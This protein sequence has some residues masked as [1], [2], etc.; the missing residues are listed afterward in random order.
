MQG[1]KQEATEGINERK[2][3]HIFE[4]RWG[5]RHNKGKPLDSLGLISIDL[6][7]HLISAVLKHSTCN[8]T[9]ITVVN[10]LVTT[11]V[12][13]VYYLSNL[14]KVNFDE[15]KKTVAFVIW[16]DWDFYFISFINVA[17]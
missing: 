5:V 17:N 11:V 8:L 4:K 3:L 7:R 13:K 14:S 12:M 10:N 6:N 9:F 2:P 16:N 15:A 1:C